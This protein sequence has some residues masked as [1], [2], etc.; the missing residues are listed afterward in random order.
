MFLLRLSK[1][2]VLLLV[3][4]NRQFPSIFLVRSGN[5]TFSGFFRCVFD[6]FWFKRTT[7]SHVHLFFLSL[8]FLISPPNDFFRS[9]QFELCSECTFSPRLRSLSQPFFPQVI[10]G[11]PFFFRSVFGGGSP[12]PRPGGFRTPSTLLRA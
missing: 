4:V 9:F 12:L 5:P 11:H 1:G 6:L 2:S 10:L 7:C 8:F 3:F